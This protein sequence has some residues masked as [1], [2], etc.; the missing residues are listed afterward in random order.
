MSAPLKSKW[1]Y[2]WPLLVLICV[3]GLLFSEVLS[4]RLA[5]GLVLL[6]GL[7]GWLWLD[8]F[9][10]SSLGLIER[11][12]LAA[13]LSLALT[14]LTT[15]LVVYLPG[16]LTLVSLLITI[17]LVII[18]GLLAKWRLGLPT[19]PSAPLL[20][21][22]PLGLSLG[23]KPAPP[24]PCS[25]ALKHYLPLI[26]V[27]LLLL[28]AALRLPRLGYAEFHEDEAEALMLGV[29][30]FQGEDY[31]LFLHRKGP[32]QMLAP[33]AVWLFSGR[34]TE[35]LARL[36]FVLSS[37]LS[38]VSLFLIGRRW[39]GWPAG[40]AAAGL[41]AINGYAIAFGRMAQYQALIFFLGPLALYSL[42]LAWQ[43]R[44]PRL[45]ILAAILLAVCLLAHFDALLL[46][47]AAAYLALQGGGGMKDEGGNAASEDRSRLI[48]GAIAL[49]LFLGIVAAFYVPY[50]LD[51]EFQ[52]T[53]GYLAGSRVGPGLLYN[54]LS[55]LQR[56]DQTYSSHFYLPLLALGIFGLALQQSLTYTPTWRW[57]L[58]G[59]GLL[60]LATLW[61]PNTWRVGSLT[62]AVL[63]W[64]LALSLLWLSASPELKAAWLL[65]GAPFIGYV[66][67]VDDPR[68]HLYIIYPGA[69]LL[70]GAGWMHIGGWV[71]RQMGEWVNGRMGEWANER[72]GEWANRRI[73]QSVA[74]G[75]M[76][77][78]VIVGGVWIGLIVGYEGIIFL[79]RESTLSQIQRDWDNSTWETIYDDLPDPRKYFGYPKREGWKTIGAL[80]ADGHFPGDFRSVNEDFIIPIWYNFGQPRSCYDTPAHFFGRAA[81][82]EVSP[83]NIAY[84]EVGQVAREAEIR[85]HI[86]SANASESVES[87]IYAL[88][89][90]EAAFDRLATPEQFTRQSEPARPLGVEFG[91]AIKLVGYTLP[92]TFVTAGET[93]YLD[94][95]WQALATPA[96]NYRAFVHLTDGQTL[97][98]QQDDEPACRLPTSI[99]RP[100]QRSMGQFRLPIKP[101]TPPGRYP[102]IIGLYQAGNLERLTITA[103]SQIGDDFLWLGD[104]EVV[105]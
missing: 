19:S 56:L 48:N 79:S 92:A 78:P 18:T 50:L 105:E 49:L 12:T 63:P 69:V 34:I 5:A 82:Q 76:L 55:L 65:F 70:A 83:E 87:V 58:A 39:F 24:L 25:P 20:L 104:I 7:S 36:P 11:L 6:F 74:W 42:Y 77:L 71:K 64:L 66:F 45:Q 14:I 62:L 27:C 29:R 28:T 16:P 44:Q 4:L 67:L 89:D 75:P 91:P 21:R 22:S 8:A 35:A 15:M 54:N 100:G 93:L 51:P 37:S 96:E 17:N 59:L 38:V 90:Y 72:M 43:E 10:R 57:G 94:L 85:L 30:L 81:G 41:W 68:T 47:P 33:L 97:W 60:L 98:A 61:L 84:A 101:N 1:P 52:N 9:L 32:A 102:L 73:G 13:G 31:A 88:E 40:L 46:L 3:N 103:G 80:R 86:F 23:T 53:A 26:L 2:L 99:W 95:Y